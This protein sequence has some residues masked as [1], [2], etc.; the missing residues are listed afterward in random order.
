MIARGIHI[1]FSRCSE[2]G[3]LFDRNSAEPSYNGEHA[4]AALIGYYVEQLAPIDTI[5]DPLFKIDHSRI[6]R[7]AEIG[8]SFGFTLDFARR[9]LGWD[10][11]GLD[12]SPLAV[13][14]AKMLGVPIENRVTA[15]PGCT[16]IGWSRRLGCCV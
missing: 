2:C 5:L 14:G 1:T 11:S 6:D 13:A 12:P 15:I 4:L 16:T 8:C 9:A 7:Y 3:S 10:V